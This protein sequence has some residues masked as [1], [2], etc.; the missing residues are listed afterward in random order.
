VAGKTENGIAKA[1]KILMRRRISKKKMNEIYLAWRA[2][3]I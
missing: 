1:G 2:K 3:S